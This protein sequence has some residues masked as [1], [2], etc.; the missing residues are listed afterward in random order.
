MTLNGT[1]P[2]ISG[3]AQCCPSYL[4]LFN[5]VLNAPRQDI[6]AR[7]KKKNSINTKDE[8]RQLSLFEYDIIYS[9]VEQCS[10]A[11]TGRL[12]FI[13]S[14]WTVQSSHKPAGMLSPKVMGLGGGSL[15]R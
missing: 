15:Q 2:F 6:T 14:P 10:K 7:K 8:D 9:T 12:L 1:F 11:V 4:F 5:S 13:K 3:T